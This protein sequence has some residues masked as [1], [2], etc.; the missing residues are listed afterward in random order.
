MANDDAMTTGC[1]CLLMAIA[2]V[3]VAGAFRACVGG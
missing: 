3:L 1:G 2:F